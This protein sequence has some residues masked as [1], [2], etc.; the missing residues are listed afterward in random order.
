MKEP[1][2][3]LIV[4]TDKIGDVVLTIP[5]A[6]AVKQKYPGVKVSLMLKEYTAPLAYN[7]PFTDN[8]LI[9]KEQNGKTD[10]AENMKLIKQYNFD[11]CIVVHP[12]FRESLAVYFSGIK[13]RIG[14]GYRWYSFLFNKKIYEHRKYGTK[15]ELHHNFKLLEHLD[16]TTVPKP[17]SVAFNIQV[18]P[19]SE[20]NVDSF[21]SNTNYDSSKKTVIIHPG[22]EGSSV[23][24]PLSGFK[25]L[26]T[27]LAHGLDV[28]IVVTGSVKEKNICK[29]L[30]INEKVTD[31]SGR[32]NLRELTALINKTDVL[33]ANSTG[34][35]HIAAA[36]NKFVV[37]FFPN[38]PAL[39][40]TR[41]GP[42]TA[43]KKIF[44]PCDNGN[45]TRKL[46]EEKN[47]MNNININ[48]VYETI[49]KELN[50]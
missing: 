45:C 17:D 46:C 5:M 31:T 35:L 30:I 10:I 24:M 40:E 1:K 28:N 41:W 13:T 18:D 25:E 39:S 20:Q 8:V 6:E 42:Y 34:P 27:K 33:A 47:C 19:Q 48:E 2:N 12:R 16:I 38:I 50:K 44:T 3:I 21:L 15:H 7:H 14:S 29:E 11:T 36:L 37:G 9:L 26:I 32:F 22:S 43:K 4:R 23:D 49:S